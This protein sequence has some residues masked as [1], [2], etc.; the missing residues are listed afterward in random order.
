MTVAAMAGSQKG[1]RKEHAT[2]LTLFGSSHSSS[3]VSR[4]WQTFMHVH[5]TNQSTNFDW[6]RDAEGMHLSM[7]P[8]V[9]AG[10]A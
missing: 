3:G 6:T 10:M 4:A 2:L 8:V 9:G 1:L 7:L 5:A